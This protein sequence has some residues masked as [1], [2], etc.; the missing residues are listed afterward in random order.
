MGL[1]KACHLN[2]APGVPFLKWYEIFIFHRIKTI[3]P[4]FLYPFSE[5][6]FSAR[7]SSIRESMNN[8]CQRRFTV[9]ETIGEEGSV[10][11]YGRRNRCRV[12]EERTVLRGSQASPYASARLMF[13]PLCPLGQYDALD[14]FTGDCETWETS[15]TTGDLEEE[16]SRG[17]IATER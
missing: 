4:R 16:T 7:P 14:C 12:S 17:R 15:S 9:R 6:E 5:A 13:I 1:L 3:D 2:F 11:R 8:L 10:H